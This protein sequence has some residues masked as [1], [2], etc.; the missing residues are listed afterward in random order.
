MLEKGYDEATVEFEDALGNKSVTT[1][2]AIQIINERGEYSST[3]GLA[4]VWTRPYLAKLPWFS[5]RLKSVKKLTGIALA[6][7]ND[8][9]ENGSERDDLLSKLQSATDDR[10]EQMGKMEL[11]AEALT[12]LIAGSDTTSNTSCA[13]VY[14]LCTNPD[15]MKKL[16]EELD[17]ELKDSEDVPI[18][19]EVQELPYLQAVISE[20]LRYHSTSAL[21]LPRSIPVGGAT[22][23]GKFFPEGTVVSVPAYTIHRSKETFGPDADSYNPDRWLTKRQELEKYFVPFSLGPRACVGRNV[24]MEELSI[25][26]AALIKRYDIVL[27]DPNA[28]LETVEGFL[29]KPASC[30]VGLS[31]RV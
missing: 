17:R 3:L 6:R 1:C 15:A 8:R 9:L 21:G 29:R 10:G 12:Q 27:Q 20:S 22:L 11:T 18:Y 5:G 19:S 4:P 28:P 7:V 30:H 26:I 14:H 2:S 13:I 25:L 16:Q 24:A 31:R 23:A